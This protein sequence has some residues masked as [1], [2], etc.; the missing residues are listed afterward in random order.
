MERIAHLLR[1]IF[2]RST[3]A[4]KD[5]RDQLGIPEQEERKVWLKFSS[6]E[7]HFY[8][9]QLEQT[10]LASTNVVKDPPKKKQSYRTAKKKADILNNQLH[11]L[12]AACCHPQVGSSG[13]GRILQ[14]SNSVS[15]GVLSMEQILDRLIDNAKTKCEESQRV[16]ILHSNVLACLNR[17]KVESRIRNDLQSFNWSESDEELLVKGTNIYKESLELTDQNSTPI[18]VVGEGILSGC[19]GFEQTREVAR[20]GKVNLSWK[21]QKTPTSRKEIWARIDFDGPAKKI[22]AMKVKQC[23]SF[24]DE[25]NVQRIYP[26]DCILQVSSAAVGGE[27]VDACRFTLNETKNQTKS[28]SWEYFKD[29]QTN[30]SKNWRVLIQNYHNT[31]QI[32]ANKGASSLY[33]RYIIGIGIQLMEPSISTDSLQRLHI[34]NNTVIMMNLLEQK[35]RSCKEKNIIEGKVI[36]DHSNHDSFLKQREVFETECHNLESLYL[37]Y[38]QNLHHES[39]RRLKETNS[40]RRKCNEEL[41]SCSSC[42]SQPFGNQKISS[43]PWWEDLLSWC[44]IYGNTSQEQSLCEVVKED[45]FDLFEGS[46][47]TST[48]DRVGFPDFQSVEGL[49][50]AL[51]L[52]IEAKNYLIDAKKLSCI[53]DVSLLSSIPSTGEILENSQCHKCRS[54]WFQKGPECRHCKL[55]TRILHLENGLRDSTITCVLKS[56][57]KWCNST[58]SNQLS[59]GSEKINNEDH[60]FLLKSFIDRSIKYFELHVA[61]KKEISDTKLAWRTHFDLLSDYDELNQC[62]Q[63]MR[64]PYANEDLTGLTEHERGSV[65]EPCDIG[66][67]TMEHSAKQAMVF[68]ELRRNKQTLRFLRNQSLDRRKERESLYSPNLNLQKD[69]FDGNDK[70]T[71]VVCLSDFGKENKAVLS[72]GHFFHYSPCLESLMKRTGN[73][74]IVS[75]PMRCTVRTKREDILIA[76]EIPRGDNGNRIQRPINGSWVSLIEYEGRYP[77]KSIANV[78][79]KPLT[80]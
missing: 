27:F 1:A 70:I 41:R 20:D 52:R 42:F 3:K 34:L 29:F 59:T 45:L 38:A 7:R 46:M 55:E 4:N 54:D 75:C 57:S 25:D 69:N 23:F 44:S 14:K 12:R 33:D 32:K 47:E 5:V 79:L 71:C 40:A 36:E 21:L 2:W 35:L 6:I 49:Q 48:I 22:T 68:A 15:S 65:V 64:L 43:R 58:S 76:T 67:L 17:L 77:I 13:I 24:E 16:C 61:L 60:K 30:K 63:S 72:C 10:I 26:K 28:P 53:D 73:K 74:N 37:A 62:K 66:A 19:K 31:N 80:T 39:Q 18:N 50:S 51:K 56:L 8:Q 11:K 78:M 9:L